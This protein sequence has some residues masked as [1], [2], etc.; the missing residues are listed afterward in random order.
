[1]ENKYQVVALIGKSGAGKDTVQRVTCQNHPLMF[2]PI[3]SCTTRPARQGEVDGVDYHFITINEFTRKVLNGDMLEATEFRDWFYG[4]TLNAL[5]HDKINIGVFNPAGVEAL[6]ADPRLHVEVFE[7]VAS[8]KD[9]LLR[10]L[11][12]ETNPDCEEICRRFFTDTDDF[13]DLDFDRHYV[14]NY[15]GNECL[16]LLAECQ[17]LG[18]EFEDLWKA[19]G[20][21]MTFETIARWER[22]MPKKAESD[23]SED[24]E[25]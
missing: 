23:N 13:A 3:V 25:D 24:N 7:V 19:T 20:T 6:L 1:M 9:R 5:Q 18:F 17:S 22:S 16:D 4:T 12:R 21:D 11:N 15:S 2:N 8:D 14:E 10:C